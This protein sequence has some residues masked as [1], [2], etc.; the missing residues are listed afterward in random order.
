[1]SIEFLNSFFI[2]LAI[3]AAGLAFLSGVGSYYTGKIIERQKNQK[4]VSIE[5]DL[6]SVNPRTVSEQQRNT[7]IEKLP[8]LKGQSI[9]FVSRLMDGESLDYAR[10]LEE[11]FKNAGFIVGP[12]NTSLL[13]DFPGFLTAAVSAEGDPQKRIDTIKEIFDYAGIDFRFTDIRPNSV[14]I[15]SQPNTIY[16]FVGRK[17]NKLKDSGL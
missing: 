17:N 8:Q 12:T 7:L 14:T 2:W 11:I 3:I 16:I 13:D 9:V 15:Q 10:Q 1:M 5:A 4:I 6:H